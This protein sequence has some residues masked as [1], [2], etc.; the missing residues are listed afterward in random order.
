MIKETWTPTEHS[1]VKSVR[2][3]LIHNY[4]IHT[5]TRR[6]S[7]HSNPSCMEGDLEWPC[8]LQLSQNT[9]SACQ[10]QP[11]L[12]LSPT[13]TPFPH[14]SLFPLILCSCSIFPLHLPALPSPCN[15]VC[16]TFCQF[17]CFP[18]VIKKM[19]CRMYYRLM[20]TNSRHR[21]CVTV[22][23]NCEA[24]QKKKETNEE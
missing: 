14:P 23:F 4:M 13:P 3:C 20:G 7:P 19:L 15:A 8:P 9:L 10:V 16:I 11:H 12:F 2:D 18:S 1:D 24:N 6:A 5:K 22:E 21:W 17:C